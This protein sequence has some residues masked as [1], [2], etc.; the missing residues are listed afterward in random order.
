MSYFATL[1]Q[2]KNG[3]FS[4]TS[5]DLGQDPAI[6][7]ISKCLFAMV[8][9]SVDF[10]QTGTFHFFTTESDRGRFFPTKIVI[11]A[12]HVSSSGVA[13]TLD[14]GK[15]SPSYNG[16]LNAT[17]TAPNYLLY[18]SGQY[19]FPTLTS[20]TA[21]ATSADPGTDVYYKIDVASTSTH[22]TR[23]IILMGFYTNT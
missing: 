15:N 2:L 22:D 6:Q 23:S 16:W 19:E 17:L 10:K 18:G 7:T 12:E 14:I 13:P 9:A 8:T 11:C 1:T 20:V 21:T 3:E 5:P 4:P